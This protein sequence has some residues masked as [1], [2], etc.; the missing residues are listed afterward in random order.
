MAQSLV[1]I[2]TYYQCF[3]KMMFD[4]YFISTKKLESKRDVY[5][6]HS[7]KV[8]MQNKAL[9]LAVGDLFLQ[10]RSHVYLKPKRPAMSSCAQH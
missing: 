7:E 9:M 10:S 3:K 4:Y 5:N 8:P 2:I 6:L 1:Y